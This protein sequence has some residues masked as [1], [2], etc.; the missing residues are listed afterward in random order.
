MEWI[1]ASFS[2]VLSLLTWLPLWRTTYGWVRMWDFPKMQLAALQLIALIGWSGSAWQD[3]AVIWLVMLPGLLSFALLLRGILPYTPFGPRESQS[4]AKG[5]ASNISLYIANVLQ[6]NRDY[7]TLL[8]Q[9]KAQ[10]PDIILLLETDI[11]WQEACS[12]L[13]D[14]YPHYVSEPL[15]NLYGLLFFSRFPLQ[16]TVLRY[17]VQNDIPS[18]TTQVTLPDGALL[19]LYGLHPRPPQPLQDAD[20]RN[21]ELWVV[22]NEACASPLPVIVA[23]D[24]NDVG[25]S[26]TT[27]RFREISGLKDPRLGRGMFNSFNAK[28][29]FL[30]WPLDHVFHSPDIRL[31]QIRR[32][33]TIGSD[34][35]PIFV[36]FHV[37]TRPVP[38]IKQCEL[39]S[40]PI[41]HDKSIRETALETM[42]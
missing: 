24:M 6:D 39:D 5:M 30:R 28:H 34:H 32:M 13:Y 40:V 27:S 3:D 9:L 4:L 18:I 14:R 2:L 20:E 17:L 15:G 16:E 25:W 12:E 42:S 22:A 26:R 37:P 29:W 41:A 36:K 1:W 21:I 38:E 19:Q 35:F 31:G 10:D 8:G 11:G 23:G 33:P 7:A